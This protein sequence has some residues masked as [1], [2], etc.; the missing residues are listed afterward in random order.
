MKYSFM[1]KI[2]GMLSVSLLLFSCS[3][4]LDFN[5]VD[6][7]NAKPVFT[8]NLA[9][10]NL[11]ASQFVINGV[12]ESPSPYI[13]N[14]DFLK[15]PAVAN[16]LIKAELF[17]KVKNTINRGY[18]YTITLLDVNSIPTYPSITMNIPA[19][20]N[21]TTVI[22]PKTVVFDSSTIDALKNTTYIVFSIELIPGLPPLTASSTGNIILSSSLTAYFDIK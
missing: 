8:T 12:E 14:V 21:G 16:D 2:I 7:L 6:E 3:S 11:K 1:N 5:Q 10:L 22:V 13:A 4:D 18:N 15:K 19:A 9:Y 17:F 20:Y